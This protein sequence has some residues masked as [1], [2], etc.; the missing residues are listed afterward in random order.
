VAGDEGVAPGAG[1]IV[2]GDAVLGAAG[3]GGEVGDL[4]AVHVVADGADA[5]R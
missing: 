5:E 1:E 4:L 2:E 3:V